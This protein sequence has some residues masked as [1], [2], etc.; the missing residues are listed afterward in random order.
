MFQEA[1]AYIGT[2]SAISLLSALSYYNL[3]DT[4]PNKIW[5]IVPISKR[6]RR[7]DL[8]LLRITNPHWDIGIDKKQGYWIT[9]INRTLVD[10]FIY[11]KHSPLSEVL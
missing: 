3:T 2:P 4:I 1:C 9:S 11:K 8:R 6:T 10:I 7:R 5:L